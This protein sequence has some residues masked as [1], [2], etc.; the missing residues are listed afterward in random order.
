MR[1]Y[2]HLQCADP[3]IPAVDAACA[4]TANALFTCMSAC[5]QPYM[6]TLT[7]TSTQTSTETAT[8]TSTHTFYSTETCSATPRYRM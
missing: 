1:L 8:E 7:T 6:P 5:M 3:S 2:P 4:P